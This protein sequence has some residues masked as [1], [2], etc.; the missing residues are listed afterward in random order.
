ML[1]SRQDQSI[2]VPIDIDIP[3]PIPMPE[4]DIIGE[5]DFFLL[6]MKLN[7]LAAEALDTEKEEITGAA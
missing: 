6:I 4:G 7:P 2:P 5:G 3:I 1:A